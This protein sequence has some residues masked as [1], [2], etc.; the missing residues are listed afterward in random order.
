MRY[1]ASIARGRFGSSVG[2]LAA[3]RVEQIAVG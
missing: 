3:N 1:R 2:A